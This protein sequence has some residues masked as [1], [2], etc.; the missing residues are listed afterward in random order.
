MR[1]ARLP[2]CDFYLT[3][4]QKH[5]FDVTV[6]FYRAAIRLPG[7]AQYSYSLPMPWVSDER[8]LWLGQQVLPHEAALRAWLRGRRLE[9][10]EVDDI[11]QETY[12]RLMTAESVHH[13]LDVR[14]YVFQVASSVVIDH[15][16]RQKIVSIISVPDLNDLEVVSEEPSPERRAID[17]DE[18]H[19]L[20]RAIAR[21]PRKVQEVFML[22]RVH[23]L[24]QREVAEQMGIAESTV[25]KHMSRGFLIMLKLFGDGG[26]TPVH[27]SSVIADTRIQRPHV[28]KNRPR[29]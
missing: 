12:T 1:V 15:L 13:I 17:R 2:V 23:G 11:I 25:E 8:A 6:E 20:A 7:N 24:S 28:K 4:P 9:G 22:R 16:R 10:L 18:L 27:P 5:G 3:K 21:L 26:N 14:S 29:N 19:R